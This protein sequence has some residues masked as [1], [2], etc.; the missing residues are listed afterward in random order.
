VPR[1]QCSLLMRTIKRLSEPLT[2]HGESWTGFKLMKH[3]QQL[4]TVY[5]PRRVSGLL[6]LFSLD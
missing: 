5:P 6:S 4:A 3:F 1:S 2:R